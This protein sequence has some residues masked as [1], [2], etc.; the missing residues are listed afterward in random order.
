M[1][2]PGAASWLIE[3]AAAGTRRITAKMAQA[4]TLSKLHSVT[5]VDRALGTAALTGQFAEADLLSIQRRH[6]PPTKASAAGPGPLP[7][8]GYAAI[9]DVRGA[10]RREADIALNKISWE[11]LPAASQPSRARRG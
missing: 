4:V 9:V 10:M 7:T 8:L 6:P 3:S 1:L 11:S 2:G 5:A